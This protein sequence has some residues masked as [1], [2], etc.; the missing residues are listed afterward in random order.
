MKHLVALDAGGGADTNEG[1][2]R[3]QFPIHEPPVVAGVRLLFDSFYNGVE[4]GCDAR[5][6][7]DYLP[8]LGGLLLRG[9]AGRLSTKDGH[10]LETVDGLW[11]WAAIS[12]ISPGPARDF[13]LKLQCN[14]R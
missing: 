4:A 14:G 13:F 7:V 5:V 2:D 12:E 9:L 3:R 8:A 6:I 11:L 10:F 1:L